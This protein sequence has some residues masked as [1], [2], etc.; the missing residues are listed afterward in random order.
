[1]ENE[2][3]LLQNHQA[4]GGGESKAGPPREGPAL[5]QG[6]VVCGKCGRTMTVRYH[7][8]GGRLTPDY[9]CEKECVEHGG[10]PCQ[11]IP[12]GSVDEAVGQLLV[13]SVT[14]LAL[15]VALQVHDEL[16][17]RLDAAE[18]L[19]SQ[20]VQ[21]AQY[22][23][24][25]ARV[26]FMRVDPNNRLVA[27]TLEGEWNEKL[28]LLGQ[29]KEECEKQRHAGAALLGDEQRAKILTLAND[30][31]RLW[32]DPKTLDRERKRMAR[33]LLEDVTLRRGED[34]HVQARFKGGARREVLLP[35]PKTVG[36]LKKTKPEIVAEIVGLSQRHTDGEIARML[37]DRGWLSSGGCVFT[38]RI[39]NRLR[40]DYG[41][42]SLGARLRAEGWL[43]VR[44]IAALLECDQTCVNHWRKTGLLEGRRFSERRDYLFQRPSPSV[45]N[46]IKKRLRSKP[47]KTVKL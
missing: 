21:R 47:I 32:N 22:E 12:G 43:T 7:Q 20:H 38:L 31:P 34:I 13:E 24:E 45:V 25:Q 8:R 37:N 35:L 6:L 17:G 39:V 42:K 46:Q 9:T 5:L 23:A 33:L 30:F 28:R 11:R 29:A 2:K 36:E 10:A 1:M 16:Q 44:E 15:E 26:R 18:R 19:R 14:P 4:H 3:R 27:D 41:V 40:R